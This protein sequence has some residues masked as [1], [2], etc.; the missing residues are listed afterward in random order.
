M[1]E[2]GH[3]LRVG[4]GAEAGAGERGEVLDDSR[5]EDF[6]EE[7][8]VGLLFGPETL[9]LGFEL[10]SGG[11]GD[12]DGGVGF[13]IAKSGGEAGAVE[14]GAIDANFRGGD[15]EGFGVVL[16][17]PRVAVVRVPGSGGGGEFAGAV[18]GDV[19][20]GIAEEAVVLES[21]T[22]RVIGQ[23]AP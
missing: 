9:G 14:D 17:D 22:S 10:G 3:L 13:G 2:H 11:D 6:Q 23:D 20:G 16:M 5:S 1:R 18:A 19:V 15:G 4:P 21:R 7:I 12:D 8:L